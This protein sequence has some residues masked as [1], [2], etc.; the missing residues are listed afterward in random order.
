M[1]L[2]WGCAEQHRFG[3]L[4]VDAPQAPLVGGGT[5][6]LTAA[7]QVAQVALA[8]PEVVGGLGHGHPRRGWHC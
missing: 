6:E 5:L 1:A 2:S 4:A 3:A 8:H 7:Q